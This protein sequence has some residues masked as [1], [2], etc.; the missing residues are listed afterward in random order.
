[1]LWIV[2]DV[3]DSVV[4][5]VNLFIYLLLFQSCPLLDFRCL[6]FS[7]LHILSVLHVYLHGSDYSVH[8]F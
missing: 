6:L 1:M 7:V 2:E 4:C 3:L 5:D 8:I